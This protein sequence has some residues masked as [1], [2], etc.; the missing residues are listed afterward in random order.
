MKCPLNL[1]Q[2]VDIKEVLEDGVVFQDGSYE[3]IDSILYCT[4]KHAL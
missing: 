3:R 1:V 2:K 4:G